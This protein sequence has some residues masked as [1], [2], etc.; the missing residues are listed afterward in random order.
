MRT[1]A[2][3]NAAIAAAAEAAQALAARECRAA[4]LWGPGDAPTRQRTAMLIAAN[5]LECEEKQYRDEQLVAW[6]RLAHPEHARAVATIVAAHAL[7]R[8]YAYVWDVLAGADAMDIEQAGQW[9][10][11]EGAFDMAPH[12]DWICS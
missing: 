3:K 8:G 11:Q 4:A 9:F 7:R 10:E 1:G 12:P 5:L 6:L 2:R